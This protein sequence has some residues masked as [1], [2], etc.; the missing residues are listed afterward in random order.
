MF[1]TRYVTIISLDN[2]NI[3]RILQISN[4]YVTHIKTIIFFACKFVT[5]KWSE[6]T[7]TQQKIFK[8]QSIKEKARHPITA[9]PRACTRF[10]S[11]LALG[12]I[13]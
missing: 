12:R 11:E 13:L 2:E 4:T 7:D 6:T 8:H 3:Q 1:F 10:G 9:A 5:S